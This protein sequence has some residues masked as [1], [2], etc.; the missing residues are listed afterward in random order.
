MVNAIRKLLITML[1]REALVYLVHD[2]SGQTGGCPDGLI[3]T[4]V[5]GRGIAR[6]ICIPRILV[7]LEWPNRDRPSSTQK[8][9]F[10]YASHPFF[11]PIRPF[12]VLI[13]VLICTC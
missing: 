2:V 6:M 13:T 8:F 9:R 7:G 4:C 3:E 11:N 12:T 10:W 5:L 1:F